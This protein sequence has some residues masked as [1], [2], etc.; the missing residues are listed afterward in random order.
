[1][2]SFDARSGDHTSRLAIRR[3][4]PSGGREVRASLDGALVVV[5]A[6][7][8]AWE[9]PRWTRAVGDHQTTLP[10]WEGSSERAWRSRRGQA[11]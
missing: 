6:Q 7:R 4:A 1:M 3:H 11:R 2:C 9:G 8:A 5:L 10:P